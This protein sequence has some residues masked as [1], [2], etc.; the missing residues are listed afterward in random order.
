MAKKLSAL[1]PRFALT[2][3]EAAAS[4]GT[5][6]ITSTSTSGP[7]EADSRW[8]EDTGSDRPPVRACKAVYTGR[9]R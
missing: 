2:P 9:F 3:S 7:S 6:R 1:I 8:S 5:E 4:L